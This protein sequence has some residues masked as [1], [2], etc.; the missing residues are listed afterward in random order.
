MVATF[1]ALRAADPSKLTPQGC[2]IV[3][4]LRT[5]HR[6]LTRRE[7]IAAM[8][9]HLGNSRQKPTRVLSFYK[10]SLLASGFI[11]VRKRPYVAPAVKPPRSPPP[12]P[13]APVVAQPDS[14]APS[15]VSGPVEVASAPVS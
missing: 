1:R 3:S 9:R 14:A 2:M 11:E 13:V 5:H 12:V 15:P 4:V 8:A 7:L 6:P 10:K